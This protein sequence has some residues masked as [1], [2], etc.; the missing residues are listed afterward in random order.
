[1]SSAKEDIWKMMFGECD[2]KAAGAKRKPNFTWGW[3]TVIDYCYNYGVKTQCWRWFGWPWWWWPP[4]CCT[5]AWWSAWPGTGC[6]PCCDLH[7]RGSPSRWW[8]ARSRCPEK[9]KRIFI[10]TFMMSWR[11]PPW[12][13]RRALPRRSRPRARSPCSV[14][15]STTPSLCGSFTIEDTVGKLYSCYNDDQEDVFHLE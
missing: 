10:P 6:N 12:W 5:P 13:R 15:R 9:V 14:Q 8:P 2:M 11:S 4:S 3:E 7:S 1:M